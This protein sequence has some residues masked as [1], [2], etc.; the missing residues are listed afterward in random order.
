MVMKTALT[1]L[2]VLIIPVLFGWTAWR[3]LELDGVLDAYYDFKKPTP[4]ITG[5]SPG[6]RLEPI[7][8]ERDGTAYQT[9]THDPVYFRVR[10]TRSFDR[11]RLTIK[12][13][14]PGDTIFKLGGLVDWEKYQFD[15]KTFEPYS[16]GEWWY[17]TADFDLAR[18]NAGDGRTYTFALSL[19]G[20]KESG[21]TVQ[22]G[23]IWAHLERP[24]EKLWEVLSRQFF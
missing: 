24:G 13:K 12:F 14:N 11:A 6:D 20:I 9:V 1:I 8:V 4:F 2:F 15:I 10:P 19:P 23:A 17:G 3:N 18:L 7:V 22:I 21:K 5:L 16:D